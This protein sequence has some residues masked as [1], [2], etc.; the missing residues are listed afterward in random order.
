MV[1]TSSSIKSEVNFQLVK[2]FVSNVFR[3]FS[4]GGHVRYGLVVFGSK[5]EVLGNIKGWF[6]H[7]T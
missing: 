5:A 6:T 1:D 4:R 2:K 7:T 3:S